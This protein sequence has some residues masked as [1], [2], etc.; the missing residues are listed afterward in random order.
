MLLAGPLAVA[1]MARRRIGWQVD[2]LAI[3]NALVLTAAIVPIYV[4]GSVLP[5]IRSFYPLWSPDPSP[6]AFLPY[7]AALGV[8]I[9]A[10]E[11]YYRGLLCVGIADIGPVCILV[12]PVLYTIW[13]LGHPPIELLLSAPA[14]ILFGAVDYRSDS[15]L[16]S[17]TAHT[18]GF[19]TLMWLVSR[20]PIVPQEPILELFSW[21]PVVS[22]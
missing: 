3:R 6:L 22:V 19:V 17:V 18:V 20:P 16:P 21:L 10:T 9:L 14:D 13:H 11:T 4:V 1:A 12:S 15:I 7:A 8:I 2:R 5:S